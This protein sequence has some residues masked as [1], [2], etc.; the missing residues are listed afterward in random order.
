MF[1]GFPDSQTRASQNPKELHQYK[2]YVLFIAETE[3]QVKKRR[4]E[5]KR[6]RGFLAI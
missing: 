3:R 5:R 4:W 1:S 2:V 6:K